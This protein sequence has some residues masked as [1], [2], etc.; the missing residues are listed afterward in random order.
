MNLRLERRGRMGGAGLS[1]D[2]RAVFLIT[3]GRLNDRMVDGRSR[4]AWNCPSSGPWHA[5]A[6]RV[7][8]REKALAYVGDTKLEPRLPA[9]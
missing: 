3:G 8:P 9:A 7:E 4:S 2:L 5:P 1:P 6:L